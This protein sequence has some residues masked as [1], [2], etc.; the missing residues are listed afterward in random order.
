V[1]PETPGGGDPSPA[2]ELEGVSF[3]YG[4]V[5]VLEEVDLRV[6][7]GDFLGIIGPNGAGKTTLLKLALGLLEPDGGRLRV[8][9][10]SP[11]DARGRVGYVP[12]HARFQEEFPILVREVVLMGRLGA[13]GRGWSPE[14][15]AAAGRALEQVELDGLGDRPV[16]ELSGGQLQRTLVARALAMEPEL[17]LLDEPT[18]S[19]DTRI[20]RRIYRL[21][22]ELTDRMTVVLVSHD[23][24]VLS[25]EVRSVACLNR[26]LHYHG[27]GRMPR[28]ALEE[29]YGGEVELVAHAPRR[30]LD[31]HGGEG[32]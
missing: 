19:V 14:D 2:L 24:G 16:G 4:L 31:T 32:G 10:T 22:D 17:L 6:E 27:T 20:G 23:I 3:S 12:Q 9:G 7:R 1:I 26:R 25:R 8:L 30:L 5:P 11:V 18:A 28:E 21:M 29:A 15:R 13:G